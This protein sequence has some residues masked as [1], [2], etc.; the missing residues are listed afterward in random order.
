[1][2]WVVIREIGFIYLK[3]VTHVGR[4]IVMSALN[5][6]HQPDLGFATSF[7]G[8]SSQVRDWLS[9]GLLLAATDVWSRWYYDLG[10]TIDS[11]IICS[12]T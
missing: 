8:C 5:P 7:V 6:R 9:T 4:Q 3:A 11:I 10:L 2:L 1:M 12:L